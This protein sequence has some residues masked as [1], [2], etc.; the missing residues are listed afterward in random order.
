MKGVNRRFEWGHIQED[1]RETRMLA[2]SPRGTST[3][4]NSVYGGEHEVCDMT[5]QDCK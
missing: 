1:E 2:T 5:D 4:R 3:E